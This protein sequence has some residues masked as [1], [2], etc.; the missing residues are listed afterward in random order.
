MW[1]VVAA[2]VWVLAAGASEQSGLVFPRARTMAGV[3]VDSEGKPVA[4]AWIDHTRN[5]HLTVTDEAGRFTLVT[6]APQMVVRKPGYRIVLLR[7]QDAKDIRVTVRRADKPDM[8]GVMNRR[9]TSGSR[10]GALNFA[11]RRCLDCG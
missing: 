8:P 10:I 2:I 5:P 3:V 1:R 7:A 9:H 11:F 6:Q 4:K